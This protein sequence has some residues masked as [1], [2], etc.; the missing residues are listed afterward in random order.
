MMKKHLLQVLLC[1]GLLL[2][3]LTVP[4]LAADWTYD[5]DAKTLSGDILYPIQNVTADENRRLTIGPYDY[6]NF[7]GP[8]DLTGTITGTDGE[9]YTLVAIADEAFDHRHDIKS[10]TLPATIESIGKSAFLVCY[11][12][13]TVDLSRC[14]QLTTIPESAFQ[15]CQHLET[16]ILPTTLTSIGPYA[17]YYCHALSSVNLSECT[18]LESLEAYAFGGA[19]FT[20]LDL[21]DSITTLGEGAFVG[22]TSLTAVDLS[23]YPN[24]TDISSAFRNCKSL[25]S[26][27]MPDDITSLAPK[28]FQDCISLPSLDLSGYRNLTSIGDYA[29]SRCSSLTTLVPPSGLTHIGEYA[30]SGCTALTTLDLSGCTGFTTIGEYAFAKSCLTSI[31]LPTTLTSLDK[32]AFSQCNSLT[33]LDLSA[34]TQLTSIGA[35][36]FQY[37]NSLT[38]VKLPASLTSIEDSAFRACPALTEVILF[39]AVPPTLS[40]SAFLASPDNIR[41]IVPSGSVDAYKTAENWKSRANY[42]EPMG[43]GLAGLSASG[44]SVSVNVVLADAPACLLVTRYDGERMTDSYLCSVSSSGKITASLSGSGSTYKAFLLSSD[45]YVPLCRQAAI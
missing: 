32:W 36:A 22:C 31:Q 27:K 41:I 26:I 8:L 5:P 33:S 1:T 34:C 7:Q 16:V 35:Y 18:R 44:G 3:L 28:A 6:V 19:P 13:F 14:T 43:C 17:F 25:T 2:C 11:N 9:T 24:L 15:A 20:S 39:S 45:T 4:A 21:P 40:S 23:V 29:F 37:F 12:L 10:L 30:F 42:I 38:S